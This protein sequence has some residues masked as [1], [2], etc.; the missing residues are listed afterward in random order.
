M[1]DDFYIEVG[2]RIRTIREKKKYTRDYV[3][4]KT[5]IS[6][7][8]LYE[9]ENGIK[10]FSADNLH[11]ISKTLEVSSEYILS[12]CSSNYYENEICEAIKMFDDQEKEYILKMIKGIYMVFK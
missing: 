9:I 2:K 6:A 3:S 7:K 1:K 8:F 5:G 10:G 12:G 4:Y 11:K